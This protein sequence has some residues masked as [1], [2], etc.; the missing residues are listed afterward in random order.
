MSENQTSTSADVLVARAGKEYRIKRYVMI[1]AIIAMGLY[2]GYD[3]WYGWPAENARVAELTQRQRQ[4]Q[5]QNELTQIADQLKT[6]KEHTETDILFQKVL[7]FILPIVG[8]A[9]LAWTIRSSRGQYRLENQQLSIPG[10]PTISLDQITRIDKKLWDRK[11][12]VYIEYNTGSSIG[13]FKLDDFA[14]QAQPTRAIFKLIE[15]HTQ[16][17]L[18]LGQTD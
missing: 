4:T 5:D 7:F 18:S 13:K 2:F 15:Q 1:V 10:H 9:Y 6:L 16:D 12:I 17:K 3:G 11:G 8:F 14:Y